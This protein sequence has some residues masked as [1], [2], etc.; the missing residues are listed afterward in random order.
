MIGRKTVIGLTALCA[1]LI[2]AFAV[3]GASAAGTT[4]YT[5][6]EVSAGTGTFKA[7]HCKPSDAG[8]GNFSHV[9]ITNGTATE[10]TGSDLNTGGEHTGARLKATVAG[11]AIELLAREVSG[12][13]TMSNSVS[14]SEMVASGEGKIVYSNVTENLLGCKVVGI[15]GGEEIVETKQLS[16]TTKGVGKKL[17][18]TPTEGNIFAEFKLEGCV[19][20]NTYKVIGSVLGVPDG[21]NQQ[22]QLRNSRTDNNT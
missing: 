13:G 18:F 1:L 7:G 4:A 12:S 10:I 9:S 2:C 14:G 17:K 22:A 16:A 21:A 8:T 6:K 11:S 19:V 15:P 3:Q 20:A 5:C